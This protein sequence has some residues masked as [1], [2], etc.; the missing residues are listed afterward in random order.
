[1][2]ELLSVEMPLAQLEGAALI[3]RVKELEE[4]YQFKHNLIQESAYGSLLRNDRRELHRAC[5][6][7][8]ESGYPNDL[9]ENAALLAQHYAQAGDERRT[10]MYALRAG[11]AAMRLH[12]HPEALTQY[13]IADALTEQLPLTTGELVDVYQKRGRVLE[14]MGRYPEAVAAYRALETLGKTRNEP[15]LEIGAL[16]PLG[17]MYI[18]PNQV[19][20]LDEALRISQSVLALARAE[21]DEQAEARALWNLQQHSYFTGHPEQAVAYSQQ[22][23]A[24]AD[25][26]GLDEL[27][28]YIL[29]DASRALTTV[30]SV[31]VALDALAVARH[32]WRKIG[33][34]PMLVDNLSSTADAAQW[35]GNIQLA[36]QFARESLTVS[37]TIGN[38]WN[39]A[40]SSSTLM[41]I[42][43]GRGETQRALEL[44]AQ[45]A[46]YSEQGGFV[47]A[48]KITEIMRAT[49]YGELGDAERGLEVLNALPDDEQFFFFQVWRLGTIT[50]LELTRHNVPA[51]RDCLAQL[52]AMGA[53]T[54]LTSYGP[55]Y[56]GLCKAGLALQEHRYSDA[57]NEIT[58]LAA[59]MRK[60]QIRFFLPDLLLLQGQAHLGLNEPDSAESVLTEAEQLARDMEARPR[61]WQILAERVELETRRNHTAQAA[62]SRHEA[63]ALLHQLAEFAPAEYRETFLAQPHVRAVLETT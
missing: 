19:Q 52:Q 29:N 38:Y 32:L 62:A 56:M 30:E 13:E 6:R 61:L 24:I 59:R 11:D 22:A 63:R 48:A 50:L 54:D 17:T 20:N 28:A 36:E 21:H 12:A 35:G 9:D 15:A 10:F 1:M 7:A 25:R 44:G 26:L 23:L 53:F 57:V 14:L 18:F 46:Q 3:R 31:S 51:V 42:H 4:A 43:M 45:T 34:M 47:L 2:S 5:A 39:L 41:Q 8:I 55:S 49:I 16:L 33:N 58:P 40:Y 60:V 37:A 27:R